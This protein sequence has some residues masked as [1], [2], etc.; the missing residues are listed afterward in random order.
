[1]RFIAV[2]LL[3]LASLVASVPQVTEDAVAKD[4][5]AGCA[6]LP[7]GTVLLCTSA[8]NIPDVVVT[9]QTWHRVH[10][11]LGSIQFKETLIQNR[12]Q[13]SKSYCPAGNL[14]GSLVKLSHDCGHAEVSK[15]V[16]TFGPSVLVRCAGFGL[17][18]YPQCNGT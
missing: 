11:A 10:H 13:S 4:P 9:A 14:Q 5:P 6:Q 16:S 8:W 17:P 1:M 12:C 2:A 18:G 3:A 15:L 7:S